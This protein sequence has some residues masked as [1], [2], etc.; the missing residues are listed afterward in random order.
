MDD[1]GGGGDRN[2]V[3]RTSLPGMELKQ[4]PDSPAMALPDWV[5]FRR[6]CATT[7]R[8]FEIWKLRGS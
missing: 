1:F 5:V 3:G 6:S 8:P 2:L 7:P 4:T